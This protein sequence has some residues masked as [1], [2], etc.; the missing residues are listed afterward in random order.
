[1]ST[2]PKPVSEK[3]FGQ[4]LSNAQDPDEPYDP[5]QRRKE[6]GDA[7]MNGRGSQGGGS[8]PTPQA[9]RMTTGS[10]SRGAKVT[11]PV[12]YPKQTQKIRR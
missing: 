2:R 6:F 5:M 8:K 12:S 10:G 11:I 3:Y 9:T 4:P 1:M 7:H